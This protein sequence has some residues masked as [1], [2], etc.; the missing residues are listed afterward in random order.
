M[1]K[2]FDI[3]YYLKLC[4]AA[5][6]GKLDTEPV[7]VSEKHAAVLQEPHRCNRKLQLLPDAS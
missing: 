6:S 2:F 4:Q 3:L 1:Y 5:G 7:I